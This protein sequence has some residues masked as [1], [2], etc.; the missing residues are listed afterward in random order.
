MEPSPGYITLDDSDDEGVGVVQERPLR[1]FARPF[2]AGVDSASIT[3]D[4]AQNPAKP[5]ASPV[6]DIPSGLN[7]GRITFDLPVRHPLRVHQADVDTAILRDG[8]ALSNAQQ[9]PDIIELSIY[10]GSPLP[11]LR[12]SRRLRELGADA[13]HPWR[14]RPRE[15]PRPRPKLA[16]QR[17]PRTRTAMSRPL[18]GY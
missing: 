13:S 11:S 3:G 15:T 1:P 4:E 16:S 9:S 17:V 10:D 12:R 7:A 18:A 6:P 14:S 8:E 5:F 2:P